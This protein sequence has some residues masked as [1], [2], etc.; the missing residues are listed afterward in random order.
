[1]SGRRRLFAFGPGRLILVNSAQGRLIIEAALATD[2][3]AIATLM[4]T[5]ELDRNSRS[6]SMTFLAPKE[7]VDEDEAEKRVMMSSRHA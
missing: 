7:E 6:P 5:N 1:M 4:A 2:K 3:V